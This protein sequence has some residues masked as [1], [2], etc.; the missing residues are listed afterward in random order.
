MYGIIWVNGDDYE[1]SVF[2]NGIFRRIMKSDNDE[3]DYIV[4]MILEF[5]D[6]EKIKRVVPDICNMNLENKIK[7]LKKIRLNSQG[8][9]LE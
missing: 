8:Y 4:D 9:H 2:E 6:T 5:A 1:W 3:H 7:T